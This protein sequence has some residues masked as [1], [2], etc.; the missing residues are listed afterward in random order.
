MIIEWLISSDLH[1]NICCGSLESPYRGD[2]GDSNEYPQLTFLWK[3]LKIYH[4]YPKIITQL[5]TISIL[6]NKPNL[7]MIMINQAPNNIDF[8]LLQ[9][10]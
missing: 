5:P 8:A 4:A 3:N 10:L 1:K 9:S 7:L 2:S 6:L